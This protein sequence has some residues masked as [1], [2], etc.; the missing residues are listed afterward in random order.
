MPFL[1][2][3]ALLLT[4]LFGDELTT[5]PPMIWDAN[6]LYCR[7]IDPP[8]RPLREIEDNVVVD[9]FDPLYENGILTT[10]SGGVLT[11]PDLR[12]QAQKITYIRSLEGEQPVFN[13]YCEGKLL[14]DYQEWVLV[15][16]AL[17][18][19]FLTHRGYIINGRTAAP[20]WYIGGDEIL[21]ME[22]GELVVLGGY[23]TTS[24]GEEKEVLVRSPHICLS[25]D[26]IITASNVSLRVENVPLLWLPKFALDLKNI[27]HSPF[28]FKFGWGGFMSSYVS[29]LYRFLSWGD[30]KGTARLD[31]FFK[32]GL[33]GGIETIY[34][35]S[36]RPT[37]F[38][39]RSY[40]ANDIA[41]A[42]P[43]RRDR[44]RFEGTFY[45]RIYG[46]TI[47]GMYDV[48]SDGEMASDFQTRDFDLKTAGRTQLELRRQDPF[49]ITNLFTRVRVNDFQS[50][51]QELPSFQLHWHPFE[52]PY[53][54]IMAENV[55]KASYLDYVFSDD[56][57]GGNDF[58]SSRIAT[59]PFFYRPFFFGPLTMTPEAGFIG[60][61]Y[62]NTPN[63]GG[64]A[65]QALGEFGVRLETA[66]SKCTDWWKHVVEPYAHYQFLTNPR[67]GTD[68]H[69]IFT[70]N[71]GWDR[72]NLVRF[73][74]RNSLFVKAPCGVARPIWLDIWANAFF[75]TPT[76]PSTI[77]IGYANLEWQPTPYIY[78]GMDGGWHFEQRQLDYYNARLDWTLSTNF[79]FGLEYRHRSR[80]YWRK[81]DFY[82]FI[83]ESVRTQEELLASPLSDHRDIFLF[84][85]F[86]RLSP[87]WSAKFDLRHGWDREFQDPFLEYQ[88][89]LATI[90]FQHWKLTFIYEKREADNRYSFSFL[91]DPGPPP[92]R[93]AC[94]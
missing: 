78:I 26:R 74:V 10:E 35:P 46:F 49:W 24:E 1:L 66:L 94:L 22:G 34:N 20:P 33:G 93:K 67:V 83:L 40:Y 28:G 13:V 84:R 76:I 82:N 45:D 91:L 54:G 41:I 72:L 53:T 51:N 73:G 87:D 31:A 69:F 65:G 5:Q 90:L 36:W 39:T 85:F 48:V 68:E 55:F 9:L 42:D 17:Y 30:L 18:Y 27:G 37:Q 16:D 11:A 3:L 43:T 21:L 62:S 2:L 52:I 19:D 4:P 38:Y 12:I 89:E 57:I 32:H 88:F 63:G 44:Y 77:P 75:N 59:H 86:T 8:P 60:I 56:V 14:I 92:K 25:R 61:A 70:I 79:A 58:S 64:S 81:A 50:V 15:G 47:N 71:D 7:P 80:F 29:V 6:C 23:I